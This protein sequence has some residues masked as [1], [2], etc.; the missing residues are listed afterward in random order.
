MT[1][2]FIRPRP[3]RIAFL[4]EEHEHWQP[5]LDAIFANC[6]GRWGGRFNLVVP[7]ENGEIRPAYLPWLKAYDADLF[8]SYV[9]LSESTVER[10]HEQFY[11]SS[12]I[13]HGFQ[14]IP[15][16][17]SYAFR[18]HLPFDPLSSLSASV[19]ASR[20]NMFSEPQPVTLLDIYGR[21]PPPQFLQENFGCY[22][23]SLTPWPIPANLSEYVQAVA[24]VEQEIKDNPTF[25]PRPQGENVADYQS[26]LQRLGAQ[27]DL[28]GLALLSASLCPRLQMNDQRWTNR[29]NLIV[30]DSFADRL[31]FW[32]ASVRI[33]L[34]I[35]IRVSSLS[36]CRKPI[37]MTMKRLPQLPRL[38]ETEFMSPIQDGTTPTSPSDRLA[39]VRES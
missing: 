16:R 20:G 22:R 26:M 11:P 10:L 12:L 13:R 24:L 4:V 27:R 18:P 36:R 7:C 25:V 31:T 3:V 34:F 23:E 5:M 8:Y 1:K 37:S 29:V 21:N 14:N 17:D 15:Q 2:A 9:D 19:L 38:S 28:S 30:G 32:N 39:L 33:L 6:F 35:S